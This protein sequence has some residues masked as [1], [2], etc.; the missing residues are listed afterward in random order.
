MNK[1]CRDRLEKVKKT[2]LYLKKK[3]LQM[4]IRRF[5]FANTPCKEL[6]SYIGISK[7]E[8]K[9]YVESNLLEG[10]TFDNYGKIWQIDHIVP[11]E[12]F[13]LEIEKDR[14]ACFNFQ[15]TIPMFNSDNK[16]KG[17]S[18]HFSLELLKRKKES[19]ETKILIDKCQNEIKIRWEKY[20]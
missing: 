3:S 15:N 20:F 7:E 9:K 2:K 13:N 14:L 16:F 11:V 8:F 18:I 5:L 19:I 4:Q 17:A 1:Y 12:L 10:M 6:S